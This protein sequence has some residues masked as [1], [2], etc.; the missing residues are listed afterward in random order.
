MDIG[1]LLRQRKL[2]RAIGRLFR[3]EVE[4]Y[5]QSLAPLLNP[6]SVFGPHVQGGARSSSA[7]ADKALDELRSRYEKIHATKPF[8]LRKQFDIPFTLLSAT[9]DISPMTYRHVAKGADGEKAVTVISP[10]RWVVSFEGFGPNRLRELLAGATG[11]GP[12]LQHTVLHS[13]LLSITLERKPELSALFEALRFPLSVEQH[14]EFGPLPQVVVSSPLTTYRPPDDIIIESTEISGTSEFEEIADPEQ[15]D[16][17][18]D[19][20]RDKIQQVVGAI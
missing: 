19:P 14:D 20:L 5:L 11:D 18:I 1:E 10:L 7:S 4:A 13:L 16:S 17:L 12:T 3:K 8:N 9:P 6:R 15:L 2:T